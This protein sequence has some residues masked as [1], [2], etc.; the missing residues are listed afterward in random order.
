MSTRFLSIARHP[1]SILTPPLTHPQP[2]LSTLLTLSHPLNPHPPFLSTP[3]QPYH[4]PSPPPLTLSTLTPP[5]APT[6]PSSPTLSPTL[7]R[8][9]KP[10]CQFVPLPRPLPGGPTPVLH[11]PCQS[12]HQRSIL[13]QPTPRDLTRGV[14]LYRVDMGTR[15]GTSGKLGG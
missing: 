7:F 6:H 4:Q 8:R 3:S 12:R 13:L 2:F 10:P 14:G 11:R 5:S 9:R 1:L 15:V